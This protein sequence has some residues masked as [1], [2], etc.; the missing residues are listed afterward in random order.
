MKF[1][2]HKLSMEKWKTASILGFGFSAIGLACS[3]VIIGQLLPAIINGEVPSVSAVEIA[4]EATV[5]V[6]FLAGGFSLMVIGANPF[7]ERSATW[8]EDR[9]HEEEDA[10]R[11][12]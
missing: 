9:F 10:L 6:L 12:N 2:Y 11:L 3:A 8:N 7:E 5:A 1:N 4:V